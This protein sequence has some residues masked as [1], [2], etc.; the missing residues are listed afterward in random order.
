MGE[1][2]IFVTNTDRTRLEK[3]VEVFFGGPL[4]D[5]PECVRA[6]RDELGHATMLAQEQ[7]PGNVITM[8]STV[9][10]RDLGTGEELA[11]TLVYPSF[12]NVAEDKIS[13][14]T[15]L[16][17]AL[18]GHEAGDVVEHC[19]RTGAHRYEVVDI[20]YQPEAEGQYYL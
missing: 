14:L 20:M 10:L 4:N 18:L 8:N 17:S 2:A 19:S 1:K 16:G 9:L 3:T 5:E 12:N 11:R 13:V 6:L 7:I 15:P